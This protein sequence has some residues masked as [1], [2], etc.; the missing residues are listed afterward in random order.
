[1]IYRF[2]NRPA[3]HRYLFTLMLGTLTAYAL[4]PHF[5]S[6]SPRI[7]FPGVDL[8][9][10]AGVWRQINVWLLDHADISTSVCPSGHVAVAFSTAFALLRALPAR[11]ALA[12]IYFAVAAAVFTATV[13]CRYHYAVDGAASICIAALAWRASAFLARGD[14]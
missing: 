9:A 8:P 4:L 2:G 3:V 14:E 7:A 10:F 11:R 12:A 13:Y 5:P 1:V 6:V